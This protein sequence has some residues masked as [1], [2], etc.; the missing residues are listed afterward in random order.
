MAKVI[1]T[2]HN[3]IKNIFC[4]F[5]FST[6]KKNNWNN[7]DTPCPEDQ[8]YCDFRCLPAYVRCDRR[9]DCQDGVDEE[10][11]EYDR[12]TSTP[13]YPY[14]YTSPSTPPTPSSTTEDPY[15]EIEYTSPSSTSP[16]PIVSLFLFSF[17]LNVIVHVTN[18]NLTFFSIFVLE[19][20]F[21]NVQFTNAP[22]KMCVLMIHNAV[23]AD[24]IA[25]MAMMNTHADVS[26]SNT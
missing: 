17:N 24:G 2:A 19:Y 23:M 13:S 16:R 21:R 25:E 10:N 15:D 12:Y 22:T 1:S 4:T 5:F 14:S 8:F 3:C 6:E 9:R 18:Y 11:C 7:L 20:S 26:I